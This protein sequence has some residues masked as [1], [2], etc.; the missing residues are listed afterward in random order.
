MQSAPNQ[1]SGLSHDNENWVHH[2]IIL[3]DPNGFSRRVTQSILRYAGA[4]RLIECE[5]GEDALEQ[6][7][8]ADDPILIVNWHSH[9]TDHQAGPDLIRQI[10]N[11]KTQSD[12]A[13]LLLSARRDRKEIERARDSGV[14]SISLQPLAPEHVISRMS[15][16]TNR[17]RQ[18]VR[19]QG[20]IGPDRRS[21]LP[22]RGPLKRQ[23]DIQSGEV[24]PVQALRN[25]A[26]SIVFEGLR[27]RDVYAARIGRSLEAYVNEVSSLDARVDE[28]IDLHRSALARLT[29]LAPHQIRERLGVI[30]SLEQLAA[31]RAR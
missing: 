30:V 25:Q 24:E 10:R 21:G 6:L 29:C 8:Q 11:R 28:M 20:F 2:P 4:D 26:I 5:T 19:T 27:Q 9:D 16:I 23:M 1:S 15:A 12:I 22:M 14:D 18:F 31:R 7:D 17:K 13:T 3:V